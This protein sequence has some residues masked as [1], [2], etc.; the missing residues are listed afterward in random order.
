MKHLAK[1][2]A[3][4]TLMVVAWVVYAY[5]TLY[6]AGYLFPRV[7]PRPYVEMVSAAIVG[8]MAAA[9]VTAFPLARL[10]KSRAWLI[11]VVVA[12]PMLAIRIGD[13]IHYAGKNEAV[14][15]VMAWI[16]MF[17]YTGCIVSAAW[18]VSRRLHSSRPV[19][20]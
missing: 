13:L 11:A 19:L 17:V 6:F 9:L 4:F 5:A 14:L 18:L 12:L 15:V 2:L 16:E 3:V 20:A 1:I 8:S 10:F 7:V